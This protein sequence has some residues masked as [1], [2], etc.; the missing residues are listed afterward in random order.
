M[1]ALRSPCRLAQQ[2]FP[3]PSRN[4]RLHTGSFQN[5]QDILHAADYTGTAGV[6]KTFFP[7]VSGRGKFGSHFSLSPFMLVPDLTPH[8]QGPQTHTAAPGLAPVCR[9]RPE[10]KIRGKPRRHDAAM[11][12]G[13][14]GQNLPRPG[15]LRILGGRMPGIFPSW[16]SRAEPGSSG[17][18]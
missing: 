10:T 12:P 8:A 18:P 9:N 7:P 2:T 16:I 13:R 15:I 1:V 6:D 3:A 5:Q 11:Q 4:G 14:L 17:M